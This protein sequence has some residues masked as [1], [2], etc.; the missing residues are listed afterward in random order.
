M[1]ARDFR[2]AARDALK[3]N[4]L[5]AIIAF[6]I[7]AALGATSG[8]TFNFNFESSDVESMPE[9]LPQVSGPA[10]EALIPLFIG[11]FVGVLV[12][13]AITIVIGSVVSIGYAE[14]NLD[15]VD[16]LKPGIGSL[17]SHFG[18]IKTAVGASL[19]IF[20]RVFVGTFFFIIPGIIASLKYSLV[21]YIIAE[22]PDIT[23]REALARSKEI[24]W[25]NKWR[26]FC[27]GLSFI[28]WDLLSALTL[29]LASIWVC[30]YRQA[31]NAAFY[32]EVSG[33]D[34]AISRFIE[35]H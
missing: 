13:A 3:G 29:G 26:F 33:S 4:W 35:T 27:L 9:G 17:F 24:M 8:I 12:Y 30:P 21:F 22:N 6:I 5:V 31:A 19:L 14:F 15:M 1:R 25:G 2:E 11:I 20:L 18:R 16:G 32:R 34:F 28:G 7:A 10:L 23:A